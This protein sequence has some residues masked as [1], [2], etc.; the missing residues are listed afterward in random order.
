MRNIETLNSF[1][2]YCKEH[3]HERFWQAL[4]NWSGFHFIYGSNK[5][6]AMEKVDDLKN[7]FYYEGKNK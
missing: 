7:T 1:I 4:R 3:P 6:S 2:K 5:C